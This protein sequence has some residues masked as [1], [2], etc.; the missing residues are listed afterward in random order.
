V[1]GVCE[2][3]VRLLSPRLPPPP[4]PPPRRAYTHTHKYTPPPLPHT[5]QDTLVVNVMSPTLGIDDE[6]GKLEVPVET[7]KKSKQVGRQAGRQCTACGAPM[8]AYV[9]TFLCGKSVILMLPD[10]QH[11]I[12]Q[13][14]AQFVAD[15]LTNKQAHR[16]APSPPNTLPPTTIHFLCTPTHKHTSQLQPQPKHVTPPRLPVPPLSHPHPTP[17]T[18]STCTSPSTLN[19]TS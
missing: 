3:H 19:R 7:I 16:S 13:S 9:P 1:C 18:L 14:S 10:S 15:V 4:S 11:D 8:R 2:L 12:L 17:P 5:H 6:L